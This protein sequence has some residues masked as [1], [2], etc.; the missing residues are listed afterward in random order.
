MMPAPS[1]GRVTAAV[2]MSNLLESASTQVCWDRAAASAFTMASSGSGVVKPWPRETPLVP[3]NTLVKLYFFSPSMASP[4][5]MARVPG[6]ST[7]PS[8]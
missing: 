2:T 5:M 1:R 7:P 6:L 4:P 8:T 3:R